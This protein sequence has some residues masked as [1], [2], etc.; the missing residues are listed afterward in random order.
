MKRRLQA[1]LAAWVKRRQGSDKFPLTIHR[2]RLYILPSR[3]GVAFAFLLFFMLIAS[4]NYVNGPALFLTFL[5]T[6][7]ALVA[8]H[9]C[10]R[11]L[12]NVA[13]DGIASGAAFAGE[14]A[15]LSITFANTAHL[16]RGQI[17]ASIDHGVPAAIDLP[18][19]S[20]R[21]LELPVDTLRR[22]VVRIERIR[23]HTTF[24]FGLFRAWTW[25]H[26]P[27]EIIVY[28]PPRGR[29]PMPAEA[30]NRSGERAKV[31]SGTEEWMGLRA[32]RDGDSPRQVAWKAFARGAPLL[33]KEY[34]ASGSDL[35][36]FEFA[37]LAHLPLEERLEQLS[38]WVVDAEAC[39]ER[40]GLT[41]AAHRIAPDRGPEHRHRCLSALARVGLESER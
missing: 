12:L 4:L 15:R 38:R 41:I 25:L 8:M 1:R 28:P 33:V 32:F 2:R 5:L 18:R 11:N 39:G 37:A 19:R 22:G 40:Y 36:L 13:V 10:H 29:L 9:R 16:A 26:T 6:G 14:P 7:F 34:G 31:G 21:H 20:V 24:P 35:R 30:G 3:G 17:E 27:L 23:V